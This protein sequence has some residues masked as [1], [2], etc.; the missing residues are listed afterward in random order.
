MKEVD[1]VGKEGEGTD[2]EGSNQ[3]EGVSET[4]PEE[5]MPLQA[6]CARARSVL[7]ANLAACHVK[8]VCC[9]LID[10]TLAES[11]RSRMSTVKL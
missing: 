1:D 2:T 9:L 4:E 8:L 6:E 11:I 3:K 10:D 5:V 7:N